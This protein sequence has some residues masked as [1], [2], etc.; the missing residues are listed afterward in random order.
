MYVRV[1]GCM[2]CVC[3]A[4]TALYQLKMAHIELRLVIFL[5]FNSQ[6]LYSLCGKLPSSF[7]PTNV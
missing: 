2:V 6:V 5:R 7:Y 1:E 4:Q 3:R